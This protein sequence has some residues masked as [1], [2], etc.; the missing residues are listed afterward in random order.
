VPFTPWEKVNGVSA[1]RR[2]LLDSDV[3]VDEECEASQT[4]QYQTTTCDSNGDYLIITVRASLA[5][6]RP[7]SHPAPRAFLGLS[8]FQG[9]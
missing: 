5:H 3:A 7:S 2:S 6:P 9:H 8:S 1:T 4:A